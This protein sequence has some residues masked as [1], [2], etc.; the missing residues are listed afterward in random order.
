[1]D[2]SIG[3]MFMTILREAMSPLLE[4]IETLEHEVNKAHQQIATQ[5]EVI[6]S[7][8]KAQTFDTT[9]AGVMN[10]FVEAMSNG[11]GNYREF[12]SYI[13]ATVEGSQTIKDLKESLPGEASDQADELFNSRYFKDKLNDWLAYTGYVTGEEVKEIITEEGIGITEE[14]ARE[15][16]NEE[17]DSRDFLDETKAE[18]LFDNRVADKIAEKLEG[19]TVSL[20]FN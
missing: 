5:D 4:R 9:P 17:I 10:L 8:S 1:M 20:S 19:A 6:A 14:D 12:V 11:A 2:N 3:A 16:A 15:Y 7:L 18:E 13:D